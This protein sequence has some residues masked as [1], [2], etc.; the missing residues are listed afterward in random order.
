MASV[1]F[2]RCRPA[3]TTHP[4]RKTMSQLARLRNHGQS[5]W[6]DSLSR[7]MLENGSL[8]ARVHEQGL[9]GVTTKHG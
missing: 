1:D 7:Q 5:F 9:G 4:E 3:F 8:A 6:L 2:N